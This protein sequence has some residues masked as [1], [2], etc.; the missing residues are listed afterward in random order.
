VCCEEGSGRKAIQVGERARGGAREM[1]GAE[2]DLKH[3]RRAVDPRSGRAYY[4]NKIT[5]ET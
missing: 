2:H 3:W 5:R 4:Y 1:A